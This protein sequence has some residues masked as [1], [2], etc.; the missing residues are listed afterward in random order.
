[1]VGERIKKLR[2]QKKMT[3]E[4]LAGEELTKGMLS[5]I[6]NNKANP[7]MESLNYIAKQLDVDV[8]H[9]LQ[10]VS[11][12]ELRETLEKVEELYFSMEFR[13]IRSKFEKISLLI[14]PLV[15]N[16]IHGYEAARLLQLYGYSLFELKREGWEEAINKAA[17]LFDEMNLSVNRASI[18]VFRTLHKFTSHDYENALMIFIQER[19]TI[20]KKYPYVEPLARLDLDYHEAVLYF[21]TGDSEKALKKVEEALHFSK[22]KQI[23]YRIDDLYRLAAAEARMKQDKEKERY[24]LKKIKQFGEF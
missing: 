7:S 14:E 19:N 22:Q 17:K 11:T 8:S 18:A 23:F 21:A 6:E 13:K 1:M 24:Y 5:L 15:P 10:T 20:E 3:L 9:L 4:E 12:E 16:L 2:K